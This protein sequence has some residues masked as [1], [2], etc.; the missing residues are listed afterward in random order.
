[1]RFLPGSSVSTDSALHF[2]RDENCENSKLAQELFKIPD[3]RTIMLGNDFI[4]ITKDDS[5]EWNDIKTAICAAIIDFFISGMPVVEEVK[6]TAE[7]KL[8]DSDVEKEIIELI[9]TKVRPAVAQD[10]GDITFEKFEDG[11]VYLKLQGACQGCP[12][13]G[14]TLK[15][16]VENML[17]HFIPEVKSVES[18]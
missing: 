15:Q 13:A 4:S 7:R 10:G 2:S 6:E 18:L 11:V 14:I 3:V 9:E 5:A 17:K 16:G 1:M 12:S 8:G